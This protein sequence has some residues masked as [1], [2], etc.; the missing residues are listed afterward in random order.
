MRTYKGFG[1]VIAGM[2]FAAG[3]SAGQDARLTQVEQETV[4]QACRIGLPLIPV[5]SDYGYETGDYA[6]PL[7]ESDGEVHSALILRESALR[8]IP[9]CRAEIEKQ[10]SDKPTR[11]ENIS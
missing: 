2:L 5:E 4:T 6:L 1:V 7:S 10:K 3:P 8:D 11:R 9:E